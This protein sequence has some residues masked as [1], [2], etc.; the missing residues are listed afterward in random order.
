MKLYAVNPSKNYGASKRALILRTGKDN[1]TFAGAFLQP[2]VPRAVKPDSDSL[3][4]D[5]HAETQALICFEKLADAEDYT[6]IL[7][8]WDGS[9]KGID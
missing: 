7:R 2:K 3:I 1:V 5:L 9:E 6:A 8:T 4:T